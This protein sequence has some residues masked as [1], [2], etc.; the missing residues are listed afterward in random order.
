MKASPAHA[1]R[2]GSAPYGRRWTEPLLEAFGLG[3]RGA[4]VR[5]A[6]G[7]VLAL[8]LVYAVS[9]AVFYPSGV[10]NDDESKYLNQAR[11]LLE[12][13]SVVTRTDPLTGQASDDVPSTYPLGVALLTA[14]F[15]SV[16][17]LR[18]VFLVPLLSLIAAVV[19]TARWI[20]EE[21]RSPLFAVA[22]LGFPP[23]LVLGRV[24]MSDVPSAAAVGLGLWLFWRGLDRG[25]G[26]W[27]ASGFVAGAS[28]ILRV[29]NPLVFLPLY[30]GSV[31]RRERRC[32]ALV[33]GGVA[34]LGV[35]F[36]SMQYYF[37]DALFERGYYFFAPDTVMERLP[38]FLVGLLI[39]VPAGLVLALA[40]RGRRWPEVAA[41]IVLF[42]CF[43]LFQT[44]STIETGPSKRVV[45]ALR[46]FIP[47]LPLFC[48]AMAEALPR[49]WGR[50]I[51]R[52]PAAA[53]RRLE[54]IAAAALVAYL[55]GVGVASAAVHPVFA[56]WTASQQAIRAAIIRHV[57]D[58]VLVGNLHAF[59]KFLPVLGATFHP[60]ES[61]TITGEE[62]ATLVARHGEFRLVLLDRSDSEFWRQ[63]ARNNQSFVDALDPPPELLYD[64]R[65]SSTD[66]LRIWRVRELRPKP[67][68]ES[69]RLRRPPD[70]RSP[71]AR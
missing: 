71:A 63:D 67:A 31:L 64:E 48:F 18:G 28:L 27:L 22:L 20:A 56:R 66:R 46:Y 47:L 52:T 35:R 17:G 53:H 9:F 21:G 29:T 59:R 58:A 6:W 7:I 36:A 1:S 69:P 50:L 24:C 39:F 37:G 32:L 68:A 25:A 10:T 40:Y 3:E 65:P 41:A 54:T 4:G 14:P 8:L 61:H 26:W 62:M 55:L 43:Y 23:A 11:L 70:G 13:R 12:G 5:L 30:A 57:G 19:W 60:L 33:V 51:R 49:G 38:L 45:L 34:G 15:L 2:A 44:F 16:L 42:F